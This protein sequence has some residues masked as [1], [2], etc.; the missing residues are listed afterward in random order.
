M[1][2]VV[3]GRLPWSD[4]R[5]MIRDGYTDLAATIIKTAV[6]D[7]IKVLRK[8]N[9][10][11]GPPDRDATLNREKESLERFFHSQWYELY[12]G[13]LETE[14]DPDVIIYQCG[15]RAKE[16]KKTKKKIKVKKER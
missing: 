8:I 16:E 1:D 11:N 5:K 10:A 13:L 6:D 3:G 4:G 15:L 2:T 14:I 9:E 12:S 7:Y